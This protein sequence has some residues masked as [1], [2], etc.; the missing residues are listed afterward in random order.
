MLEVFIQRNLPLQMPN[1]DGLQSTRRIRDIG[2]PC[3]IIALT[4]FADEGNFQECKS[5]Y[6]RDFA[7]LSLIN[8]VCL[9]LKSGMNNFLSK[10]LRRPALKAIL[11]TYCTPIPELTAGDSS[12]ADA[13]PKAEG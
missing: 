4:A 8:F 11:K 10:P 5:G 13:T 2:F 7:V 6:S 12:N 1:L 9:G 3:P